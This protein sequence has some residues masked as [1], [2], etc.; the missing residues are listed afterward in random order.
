MPQTL[1]GSTTFTLFLAQQVESGIQAMIG[2]NEK[3]ATF[4]PRL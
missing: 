3:A 4:C 1:P 2:F